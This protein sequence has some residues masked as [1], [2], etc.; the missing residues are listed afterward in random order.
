MSKAAFLD[1]VVEIVRRIDQETGFKLL[2]R[3][4]GGLLTAVPSGSGSSVC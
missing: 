3:S 2:P 4:L 1:F